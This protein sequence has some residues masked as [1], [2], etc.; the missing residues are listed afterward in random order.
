VQVRDDNKGWERQIQETWLAYPSDQPALAPGVSYRVR[1]YAYRGSSRL[2][3]SGKR[4]NILP[5]RSVQQLNAEVKQ[6]KSMSLPKDEELY[7]DLNAAFS[8]RG[9]LNQVIELL[10]A[11]IAAGSR[12]PSIYRTLG[13]SLI[14]AGLPDLATKEYETATALA[15]SSANRVELFKA[16][17]GLQIASLLQ[18]KP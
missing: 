14:K 18:E 9:L 7:L 4:L 13:D 1:I 16:Q 3:S 8:S 6:I 17:T 2:G 10:E 11:R 15:E 12:S 5:D